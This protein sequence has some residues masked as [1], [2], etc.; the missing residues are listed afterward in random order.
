MKFPVAIGVDVGGTKIAAATVDLNRGSIVNRHEVLTRREQGGARVL[1][2]LHDMVRDIY[3][4]ATET[5]SE[6]LGIGIGIPELVN[7]AGRIKSDWNFDWSSRDVAHR[8]R[9]FGQI[10][11]ESDAR[12]A[13][14][15]ES[16][17]GHGASY[18]SFLFVTVGTGLSCA[19]FSDGRVHRGA[20]GFAIHF[21][22]SDIMALCQQC[23]AQTPFN[24]EALASGRGL[25]NTLSTRTGN[26]VNAR[27]IVEGAAGS[28]GA[29]LLKQ[30]TTALASYLGQLINILDPHA[31]I[32]CGALGTS[33]T[34][35]SALEQTTRRFIWAEEGRAVPIVCSA[36]GSDG[37]VIGAAAL[38]REYTNT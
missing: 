35:F 5:N 11:L 14:L 31:V 1:D 9:E 10:K 4:Q 17:F 22:S 33:P 34:V 13:A 3:S 32:I 37:G 20:N 21:A 7:N 24:L 6:I 28:E 8:L 26:V 29:E 2:R 23:G 15:A 12:T 38:F 16:W 30:S 36:L 18:E 19:F 25:V 27:A